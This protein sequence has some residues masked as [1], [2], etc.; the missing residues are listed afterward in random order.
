MD[1]FGRVR[2]RVEGLSM[3]R[4]LNQCAQAGVRL[5][6]VRRR[7]LR[8]IAASAAPK[9]FD[10]LRAFAGERGWRVT[11]ERAAGVSKL[12][13]AGRRRALLIGGV[14]A[15]L[16]ACWYASSCLWAVEITGAGAYEAE[17]RRIFDVIAGRF[18]RATVLVETMNPLVAKHFKEKSIEGSLAKF[19]WGIKNGKALAELLP[20]FRLVGEHSLTEG[21]A[22]FVPVYRLLDRIPFIS[23]LSN[24]IIVLEKA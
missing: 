8:S 22:E 14:A 6:G 18:A 20:E 2:F 23:N 17:V 9:D 10:A 3:E 15:F 7:S 1:K 19:T 12:R 13:G 16:M 21:M 5:Y 11:Q 4:L 24:K